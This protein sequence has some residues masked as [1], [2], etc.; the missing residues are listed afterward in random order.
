MIYKYG[1]SNAAFNRFGGTA[2][3]FW[4]TIQ[5][6]REH[7]FEEL[8]MGRSDIDNLGLIAFKEHWGATGRVINYWSYPTKPTGLPSLWKKMLARHVVSISPDIVLE[9]VGKLLYKHIG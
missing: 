7:G 5:E 4:K 2:L 8:D 9:T 3:L 6:A 1:C